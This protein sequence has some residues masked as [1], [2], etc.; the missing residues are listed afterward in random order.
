MSFLIIIVCTQNLKNTVYNTL[1]FLIHNSNW[2]VMYSQLEFNLVKCK[3]MVP[4]N[5]SAVHFDIPIPVSN[6]PNNDD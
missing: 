5:C 4:I 3:T 2:I 1:K 6:R